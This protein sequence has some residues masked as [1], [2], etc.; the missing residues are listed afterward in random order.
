MDQQLDNQSGMGQRS[1]FAQDMLYLLNEEGT[2]SSREN[3]LIP[4]ASQ[5]LTRSIFNEPS[6]WR[7]PSKSQSYSLTTKRP[8]LSLGDHQSTD[9]STFNG[10]ETR[11]AK[12][13]SHY[14]KGLLP[15]QANTSHCLLAMTSPNASVDLGSSLWEPFSLE[16]LPSAKDKIERF[17]AI[18]AFLELAASNPIVTLGDRRAIVHNEM[19]SL[20]E[21]RVRAVASAIHVADAPLVNDN[22][23]AHSS[24]NNHSSSHRK[25]PFE[26]ILETKKSYAEI[27]D[28]MML[29][30]G[31]VEDDGTRLRVHQDKR[32]EDSFQELVLFQKEYGHCRVP[33]NFEKNLVLARWVSQL[34]FSE[35]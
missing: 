30:A 31:G 28:E 7:L 25:R 29:M 34:W 14:N 2:R 11:T 20:D 35:L 17:N 12:D 10:T 8:R 21:G 27:T 4:S 33:H 24:T 26:A 6:S 1:S 3:E 16:A 13:E 18:I 9:M 15:T 32:W 19:K 5:Q 22:N 23:N